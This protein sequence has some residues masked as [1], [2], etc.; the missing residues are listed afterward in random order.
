MGW[1]RLCIERRPN[2]SGDATAQ[3]EVLDGERGPVG[4]SVTASTLTRV[5]RARVPAL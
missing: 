5:V 2:R 4:S 1:G 3:V